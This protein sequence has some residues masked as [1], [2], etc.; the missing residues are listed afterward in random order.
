MFRALCSE[1][2]HLCSRYSDCKVFAWGMG[3][4]GTN[5]EDELNQRILKRLEVPCDAVTTDQEALDRVTEDVIQESRI[6]WSNSL[7]ESLKRRAPKMLEERRGLSRAFEKRCFKRWEPVLDLLEMMI[8]IVHEVSEE[9][10]KQYR[11]IAQEQD[12]VT[13]EALSQLQPRAIL[14]A[15]EIMCL[16]KSGFPDGALATWRSL[17]ELAVTAHFISKHGNEIAYRYLASFYFAAKAAAISHNE[18]ADRAGMEKFSQADLDELLATCD[19]LKK[20]IGGSLKKDHE[21]ARPALKL[22][23]NSNIQFFHLEKDVGLDHWRPRFK[24]ATQH[25]H[26]GHR[27]GNRLLGMV[28]AQKPLHLVG[29]SNSGFVDPVHMTAITL[30]LITS[31]FLLHPVFSSSSGTNVTNI[32][33][34]DVLTM[35]SDEIGPLAIEL[36]NST[37]QFEKNHAP[38][39]E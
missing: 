24:W 1:M 10:D 8:V 21:W 14:K 31:N 16:L 23:D 26:A 20:E 11:P 13:F 22:P 29:P 37:Q 18:K 4:F 6:E 9:T 27:P 25:I 19:A 32:V 28:E 2:L 34:S 39:Q 35:I 3:M 15:R 36:E 17:H 5:Y 33:F 7:L 30:N 12:D 38:S